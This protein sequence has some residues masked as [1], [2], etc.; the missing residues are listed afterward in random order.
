[1]RLITY[2]ASIDF[3]EDCMYV[4]GNSDGFC[5]INVWPLFLH[6][7]QW[8]PRQPQSWT[9]L[10]SI[11]LAAATRVHKPN[12]LPSEKLCSVVKQRMV[13]HAES[14]ACARVMYLGE[15]FTE[16]LQ[17]ASEEGIIKYYHK[18]TWIRTSP[19]ATIKAVWAHSFSFTSSVSPNRSKQ[20]VSEA[21]GIT[22]KI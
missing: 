18:Q 1:M 3:K 9:K 2:Q 13:F 16:R 19:L 20:Q 14:Q 4:Q 5:V 21:T 22:D 8:I 11:Y 17:A 7:V 12:L 6:S 10:L 15:A